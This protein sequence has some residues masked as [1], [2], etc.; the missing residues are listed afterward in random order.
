[1]FAL[2]SVAV[3]LEIE[4]HE[5]K[6]ARVAMGGVA[7]KPWRD[8]TVEE[9]LRGKPTD[10]FFFQEAAKIMLQHAKPYKYNAFKI[11][12]A[13]R[14]VVRALSEARDLKSPEPLNCYTYNRHDQL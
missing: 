2:V 1:A 6:E 12:L 9:F 14:A 8:A 7:H 3:G 5:I 13:K 11:E 4:N 10:D